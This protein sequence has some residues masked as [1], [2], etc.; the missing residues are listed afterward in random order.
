MGGLGNGRRWGRTPP[1]MIGALIA[2]ILVL[3]FNY[4]VSSSRNLE[5]QTKMYELEGQVRRGAAE[6]G[7]AEIKK[8]EFQEEI[9][10]QKEQISH[11]ESLYKRQLEGSQ[12]TCS[13]EKGT[14]QQNI[15]SSTK[16]IQDLKGQS[17]QLN[18]D[19]RKLQKDLQSCQSNIKTLN[20][21][22][23]YDMTHCQSQVLSQKELCDER[24]AAAKL[25]VQKKMDKLI[26]PSGVS[27]QQEN[28]VDGPANEGGPV[29]TEVDAVKTVT[30]V[31]HTPSLSQPKENDPPELLTNEI[32]IDQDAP[33]DLP[34][35][36]D[37][38]KAESQT[39]PAA[40]NVKQDILLPPEEAVETEEGEAE[41]IEHLKNNLTE[42]NEVELMDAHEDGAQTEEADPGMEGMLIGRAKADET[43][44][45]Q[46][47]N[48][49]EDYDANMQVVGVI[50]LE[51]SRQRNHA[52]NIDKDM[53]DELADYNGDDENEGE[54]EADKQAELVQI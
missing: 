22:L 48:E 13:Q 53:E 15:S 7:V 19:L 47:L 43:P 37:L 35:Q 27:P 33:G 9:H 42:N 11:I 16:T 17:N 49:P 30:V 5:L 18:D 23:T 2:C 32:I 45:G 31:S 29:M 40:A 1:L 3:G 25:E 26:S 28:T 50:D 21:K 20:N 44:I 10:R 14:L 41:T 12:N 36:K 54:F 52:E 46:K 8:N 38:S 6:R 34:S 4:W 39:A 24:M 51:R